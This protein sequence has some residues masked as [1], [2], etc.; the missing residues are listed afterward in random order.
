[1]DDT[2]C[3]K[4]K[5]KNMHKWIFLWLFKMLKK[6]NFNKL[7]CMQLLVKYRKYGGNKWLDI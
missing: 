5:L 6:K 3:A 7:H 1:M 2:V 4:T